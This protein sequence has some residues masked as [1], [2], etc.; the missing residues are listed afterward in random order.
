MTTALP[1][2]TTSGDTTGRADTANP[3]VFLTSTPALDGQIKLPPQARL[4]P[5]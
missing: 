5:A 4:S 3:L 1:S 2:Y